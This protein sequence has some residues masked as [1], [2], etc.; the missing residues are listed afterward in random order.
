MRLLVINW[1]DKKHPLTGGA[2]IHI[3]NILS[4][5]A[6]RYGHNIHFMSNGSGGKLPSKE[7]YDGISFERFGSEHNFNFLAPARLKK[8]VK[9]FNPDLVIE[10][11]NK[12]PFYS[13]LYLN[14]PVLLLVPH[15]FSSTIF[16]EI[17]F[18]FATYIYLAEKLMLPVYRRCHVH[19]ISNSTREDLSAKGYRREDISVAECGIDH[20]IYYPSGIKAKRATICYTGRIM[21]YKSIG[22]LILAASKVVKAVPEAR[23]VIIGEGKYLGHLKNMARKFKLENHVDF[24]GYIPLGAKVDLLRSSHCLVYPSIKEGWGLSNIEANACGTPAIAADVP[25]LRDSVD[26]NVSGLLYPYGNVEKLADNILSIITDRALRERLEQGAI[27]WA[28]KFTWD[29]TAAKFN[30]VLKT[31]YADIYN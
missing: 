13:P 16:R 15:L 14:K 21:K 17:N 5:L 23:F 4:R 2:E 1:R 28:S 7:E 3:H 24:P 12:I 25:G 6:G 26:R 31:R 19:V 20:N 18:A 10:D 8:A 29:Q 27:R 22:H 9:E 30:D 11:V